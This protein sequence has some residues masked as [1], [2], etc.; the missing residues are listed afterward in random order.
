MS[1][2]GKQRRLSRII[3]PDSRRTVIVPLDDSLICGPIWRLAPLRITVDE[4]AMEQPDAI[5]GFRGLVRCNA[6]ALTSIPY[7]LN[8]CASTTKG[9][10]TRKFVIGCVE[11]AVAMDMQAVAVHVNI[12][13]RFEREMLTILGRIGADCSK[14]GMPLMAIMYA[15]SERGADDQ[16]YEY[17]DLA[18][19][20]PEEYAAILAHAVR[21]GVELGADIVK[22]QFS[23]TIDS[24][25]RVVEAAAPIPVVVAGGPPITAEAMLQR[26]S[27]VL[28]AGAAGVSFA[29]NVFARRKPGAAVRALKAVVH[30]QLSVREVMSQFEH[31]LSLCP[32]V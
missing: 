32:E 2:S 13:S 11:E 14:F 9:E 10:Y 25:R 5:L 15:R 17:A 24:F 29:R 21:I 20:S 16:T 28:T 4:I 31:Q 26:A 7:I 18:A 27:D 22:T 8:L 6:A 1:D 30:G 19:S 12:S 23:G 3:S